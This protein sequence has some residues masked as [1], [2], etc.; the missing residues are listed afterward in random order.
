MALTIQSRSAQCNVKSVIRG[1][2]AEEANF[3]KMRLKLETSLF[4]LVR[5]FTLDIHTKIELCTVEETLSLKEH[6][7]MKNIRERD[8]DYH[9]NPA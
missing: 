9:S 1:N 5:L 8:L 4:V 7:N 2:P 6:V 3:P